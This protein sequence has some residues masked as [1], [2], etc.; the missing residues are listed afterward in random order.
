MMKHLRFYGIDDWN[1]PVFK[2]DEDGWFYGSTDTLFNYGTPEN[3]VLISI[4][5]AEICYFGRVFNWE[6]DGSDPGEICF[7][8]T[9]YIN[10]D[11]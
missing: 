11:K 5:T 6:P 1:R 9:T 3:V 8:H 7:E 4:T 10:K 2:C